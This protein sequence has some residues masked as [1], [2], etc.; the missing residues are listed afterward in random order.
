MACRAQVGTSATDR[1]AIKLMRIHNCPITLLATVGDFIVSGGEDGYV[2][3]FDPL[4]RIVA[5]FEDLAAG[6]W[7]RR[8]VG[9]LAADAWAARAGIWISQGF[10]AYA[11]AFRLV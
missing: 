6:G 11:W 8:R 4:L 2:R 10:A 3:F 1:R 7:D 9:W 5:W